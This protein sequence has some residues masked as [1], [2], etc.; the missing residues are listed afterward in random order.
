MYSSN[1]SYLV[2]PV[3]SYFTLTYEHANLLKRLKDGKYN[4]NSIILNWKTFSD[5]FLNFC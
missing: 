2:T 3:T 5:R 1:K 4:Q